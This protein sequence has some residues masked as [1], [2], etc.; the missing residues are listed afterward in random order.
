[1]GTTARIADA[2]NAAA[3]AEI[4]AG[5]TITVKADHA[6]DV[7]ATTGNGGGLGAVAIGAGVTIVSIDN[8]V[9]ALV[10]AFAKLESKTANVAIDAIDRQKSGA[11]TIRAINGDLGIVAA[12]GAVGRV[13]ARIDVTAQV[14]SNARIDALA[15]TRAATDVSVEAKS[16]T[17]LAATLEKVGIAGLSVGLANGSATVT[18]ATRALVD[19]AVNSKGLEV[20]SDTTRTV[21]ARTVMAGIG[22][23]AGQLADAVGEITAGTEAKVGSTAAVAAGTGT[24]KVSATARN[25]A[26]TIVEG[27]ALAGAV[28]SAAGV[29]VK[30]DARNRADAETDTDAFSI[31]LSYGGSGTH[32]LVT[33]G[34]GVLASVASTAALTSSGTV[35]VA[36]VA[37]NDADAFSDAGT[38][39]LLSIGNAKPEATIAGAT[40]AELLG[41][42]SGGALEV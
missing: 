38:G 13:A 28:S 11:S 25:T 34:A 24:V 39:G 21:D 9:D 18:G 16:T 30:A 4:V 3:R 7:D 41:D 42:V 26:T 22:L 36:A 12:G 27:G 29:S 37:D 8:D 17:T 32:A 35:E 1:S 40:V 31:G 14:A 10:G 23:G 2:P 15:N 6:Y 5:G 33:T 19:G 20:L